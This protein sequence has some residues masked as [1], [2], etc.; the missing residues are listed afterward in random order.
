MTTA[1]SMQSRYCLSL[2]QL[3]RKGLSFHRRA[4]LAC[5]LAAAT[6]TAIITGALV[7]GDSVR[8]SLRERALER[9]GAIDHAVLAPGWC[10]EELASELAS[11]PELAAPRGVVPLIVARGRVESGDGGGAVA[12]VNI[13]AVPP[14][15]WGFWPRTTNLAVDDLR[16]QTA[17]LNQRLASAIAAKL[18]GDVLI[19]IEKATDVAAE[20]PT[21]ERADRVRTLR[22][23]AE[24]VIEDRGP[25]LFRLDNAQEGAFNLFLPL[26]LLQRALDREGLVNALLV[27]TET[28]LDAEQFRTLFRS[29]WRLADAGL[30]L[31]SNEELGYVR[32]ESREL[33]LTGAVLE[34]AQA[35]ANSVG[36]QT[37]ETLT[38]LANTIESNGKSIPYS[39]VT[40]VGSWQPSGKP[41]SV[42]NW[43]ELG[44]RGIVLNRWAADDLGA[45]LNDEVRLDYF[46]VDDQHEVVEKSA[47]FQLKAVVPLEG[48]A[49]DRGWTP[50]F[51]GIS[52]AE[53]YGEW[54]AP[55][56]VH[57]ERVREVD[58]KYWDDH[59]ATPKAFVSFA[60]GQRI[61]HSRFGRATSVRFRPL[62]G[63]ST[64]TYAGVL[65]QMNTRLELEI[66]SHL[67]PA[68]AG[69]V[70]QDI[71]SRS[72][73][74]ANG[75]TDFSML[76]VS[77]SFFLIVSAIVLLALVFGLSCE[78]RFREWGTLLAVGYRA[79]DVTA[80]LIRE[81][82]GI[83]NLGTL[84]GVVGGI[85]YAALLILGLKTLWK[86]AVNAPFL[87]LH[88]E[89]VTLVIGMV[90]T[91]L[92]SLVTIFFVSRRVARTTPI[93]LLAGPG[94][95]IDISARHR[96]GRRWLAGTLT[97]GCVVLA[98]GLVVVG[99]SSDSLPPTAVFFGA[100]ACGLVAGLGGVTLMI[101]RSARRHARTRGQRAL[102]SLGV[103]N[104]GRAPRR[105][106]LT[107]TVLACAAFLVVAVAA[108]RRDVSVDAP[109][110][111]SGNGGFA[112]VA[113]SDT[114]LTL[115]LNTA[116]GRDE[117][118]LRKET[119]AA[120]ARS[121]PVQAFRLRPGDDASCSNLYKPTSPRVLGAPRSFVDRGGFI[122]TSSLAESER[123]E[124]N[125]WTL[126]DREL[127]PGVIPA[128]GDQNTV[129]WILQSGLGR[130]IEI[131][132]D[133]G[134]PL[135][136]RLVAL[137]SQSIF[138]GELVVS[139]ANFLR[140]FPGRSGQSFFLVDAPM[141][142]VPELE[143]ALRSDLKDY[144]LRIETTGERLA[145]FKQVENTYLST[146][147][148]LG[149]L[150][151][152]LGTLG[153]GVVLYRSVNERRSELALLRAVGFSRRS[154]SWLIYSETS[155]LLAVGLLV[156][157]GSA[158]IS[159]IP[160]LIGP[161]SEVSV[162]GLVVTLVS[163]LLSGLLAALFAL[164]AALKAPLVPALREK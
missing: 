3:A 50:N 164:R 75:A 81:G 40:A 117:L 143:S 69:V 42:G 148:I 26:S 139:E 156:G 138:Q 108:Q 130:D 54:D 146:F 102:F 45:K 87:S 114:P 160:Q 28:L 149:G 112:L 34:A 25:G 131:E 64:A 105:S 76:F 99:G 159:V 11:R 68:R 100:G 74:A 15:F 158:L 106:L 113:E 67:E 161:G 33:L 129:L 43:G 23:T 55:F 96:G 80:L 38:Y 29:T 122:W 126:L 135:K 110:L 91:G 65:A 53:T 125:P 152:L 151:L 51:P 82:R 61:W 12:G 37:L 157:G 118:T 5:L 4:Y 30:S 17:W 57:L 63:D 95:R 72:L 6:T 60:D 8:G 134:R 85:G 163:I 49:L 77:F 46:V 120:L 132:D 79:R 93:T 2:R 145:T 9:L 98:V 21:G 83:V 18:D 109:Q 39:T 103:R 52:D 97:L 62:L 10:R 140:H 133:E 22:V 19:R 56:P 89:P 127:D 144:S 119:V 36:A 154:I 147:Q 58:E 137:L 111:E 142:V 116:S 7:V 44:E 41:S 32:L 78:L 71:R 66:L 84:L 128:I 14:T 155:M 136:L 104:A 90:T 86:G 162:L 88:I 73:R 153:L 27:S 1:P 92:L 107:V 24:R 141:A 31:A 16:G 47:T 124:K 20:T 123:E 59:R 70:L 115:S 121:A 35:A 48:V 101:Q 94:A 13:F 150:G